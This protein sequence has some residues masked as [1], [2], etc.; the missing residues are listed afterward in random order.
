MH[1]IRQIIEQ[2]TQCP[3]CNGDRWLRRW[4]PHPALPASSKIDIP[5]TR[6]CDFCDGKGS[7]PLQLGLF[8]GDVEL[9]KKIE[10]ERDL[11]ITAKERRY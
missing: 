7:I 5:V 9:L 1:S 11:P 3:R 10:A 2:A 6:V 4:I 8:S